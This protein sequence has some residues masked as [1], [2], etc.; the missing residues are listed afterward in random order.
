MAQDEIGTV[1]ELEVNGFRYLIKASVAALK[2]MLKE[3]EALHNWKNESHTSGGHSWNYI[4]AWSKS[5]PQVIQIP[6]NI[7]SED[8]KKFCADNKIPYCDSIPDLDT[9]DRR[10]PVL[11]RSQDVVLVQHYINPYV[12]KLNAQLETEKS[13]Y[14]KLEDK[15]NTIIRT[16][17]DKEEIHRAQVDLEN[18]QCAKAQLQKVIDKNEEYTKNGNVMPFFEYL[19]QGVDTELSKDP[20]LAL[21]K[22]N[23]GIEI[24]KEYTLTDAMM[25]VRDA[26]LIPEGKKMFLSCTAEECDSEL[27]I[28]RAFSTDSNGLA[29]STAK[30]IRDGKE[31]GS[32]SDEGL[33]PTEYQEKLKTT[34]KDIGLTDS[35]I[36]QFRY[37]ADLSESSYNAYKSF[38]KEDYLSEKIKKNTLLQS[39]LTREDYIKAGENASA[40]DIKRLEEKSFVVKEKKDVIDK[41]DGAKKFEKQLTA[42]RV[43][44]VDKFNENVLQIKLDSSQLEMAN[45][46][47]S[48]NVEGIG[49]ITGVEQR[50][51]AEG[52]FNIAIHMDKTYVVNDETGKP[53]ALSGAQIRCMMNS[54]EYKESESITRRLTASA[55]R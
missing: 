33:S 39:T 18:L 8:W 19:K 5:E 44:E 53:K 10:K 12:D 28:E 42:E 30:I 26:S 7:N 45:G 1:I 40:E 54:S 35:E 25:L 47:P 51:D 22:L 21:A 4:K 29:V 16:S 13:D 34:L 55:K 27:T 31:I 49:V 43:N 36:S 11:F 15:F 9:T 14:E 20:K 46:R 17:S 38:S 24:S 37:R 32:F 41:S 52:N 23:E 50:K 2:L 3:I 48:Y 6:E